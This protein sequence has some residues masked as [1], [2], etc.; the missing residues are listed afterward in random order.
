MDL[1]TNNLLSQKASKKYFYNPN[2]LVSI[3]PLVSFRFLFGLI[4][5]F[6]ASRFYL[7]GWVN[8]MYID[9]QF[10]FSFLP[11][12]KPLSPNLTYFLFA[13]MAFSALSIAF[14]F[15]YRFTTITYFSIFTY[16]ELLDKTNYLNHYYFVSIAA[17]ILIFL[18]AGKAMSLDN[19]LFKRKNYTHIPA[20]Q[21]D[22]LKVMLGAVYFFAGIAK[23]N[24]D[25]LLEALPLKIWLQAKYDYPIIGTLLIKPF[26][27]Y[28]FSWAGC[29]FDLS[30]F[31]FLLNKKTRV[32]A[33][34]ALV[35]FHTLTSI[36]FPIG[37]FP[38]VMIGL[39]TIFFDSNT[40]QKIQN[41][42]FKVNWDKQ[43]TLHYKPILNKVLIAFFA[44]FIFIQLLLPFRYLMYDGNLFWHE[45]G[46][47]FSWR[48]MLIEKVGYASFYIKAENIE[49]VIAIDNAHFLNKTQIKMLNTQPDMM[50][51]YA[52]F[53]KEKYLSYGYKNPKVYAEVYIS[54]NGKGSRLYNDP[55]VDLSLEKN[56][57]KQKTWILPYE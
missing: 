37:V 9:P 52:H 30:I 43:A 40:H 29:I 5:F 4:M 57:L 21:I 36:L 44:I 22:I 51:Q 13:L 41:V 27:A 55:S 1:S 18:P 3:A 33:Y 42:L 54:L 16:F 48:V 56:N 24:S 46:Y 8:Q 32:F 35:F 12:I 19:F 31:F 25:W 39:T 28:F 49:E 45:Q 2:L 17:F 26:T 53:L 6:S 7:N 47:R 20:Y 50:V 15:L 23:L 34:L 14:G 10:Y 38:F 11:F